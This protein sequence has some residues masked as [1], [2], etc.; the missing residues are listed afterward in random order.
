ML[1]IY[2]VRQLERIITG[3]WTDPGS[4]AF[5]TQVI[6]ETKLSLPPLTKAI[7]WLCQAFRV[8]MQG[9]C[10][11]LGNGIDGYVFRVRAEDSTVDMAMKVRVKKGTKKEFLI[12]Q[13]VSTRIPELTITPTGDCIETELDGGTVIGGY[14]MKE[15]GEPAP[16]KERRKILSSLIALHSAGIVHGDPRLSN[17]LKVT[18]RF[19]FIDFRMSGEGAQF[20]AA[21]IADDLAI[22][23][24]S[25]YL[26][27]MSLEQAKQLMRRNSVVEKLKTYGQEWTEKNALRVIQ[28]LINVVNFEVH[29]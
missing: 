18:E 27:N 11:F 28:E 14:L 2:K 23:V 25:A 20:N 1:Y 21:S 22:F 5:L 13:S 7:Q 6:N 26:W 10:P 3:N 29:K 24:E 12:L 19:K 15:V 4:K 17:I 16:R 8:K 9:D